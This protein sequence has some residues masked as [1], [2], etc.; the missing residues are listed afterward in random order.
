MRNSKGKGRVGSKKLKVSV[1]VLEYNKLE[2]RRTGLIDSGSDPLDSDSANKIN[3]TNH[4]I[5]KTRHKSQLDLDLDLRLV[6]VLVLRTS[7]KYCKPTYIYTRVPTYLP[8]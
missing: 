4:Q 3:E 6:L 7:T 1:K 8:I 5:K 2:H